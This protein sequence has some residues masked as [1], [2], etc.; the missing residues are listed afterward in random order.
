MRLG[1][2]W[3][4][5]CIPVLRRDS[6]RACCSQQSN[7]TSLLQDRCQMTEPWPIPIPH[8]GEEVELLILH[9][10]VELLF[11]GPPAS[12]CHLHGGSLTPAAVPC[13]GFYQFVESIQEVQFIKRRTR[14]G[15]YNVHTTHNLLNTAFVWET[16]S[17][18]EVYWHWHTKTV[19]QTRLCLLTDNR[20]VDCI[21]S[22]QS[23]LSI[24]VMNSRTHLLW[25]RVLQL[26]GITSL[27]VVCLGHL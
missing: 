25:S 7:I 27:S 4:W 10:R 14:S 17:R 22:Q 2:L 24:I 16:D 26:T 11:A 21:H 8:G 23:N 6:T 1:F 13:Q 5:L 19:N 15:I 12:K 9:W 18:G 3:V 20:G